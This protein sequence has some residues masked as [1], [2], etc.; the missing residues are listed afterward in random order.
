MLLEPLFPAGFTM[1]IDGRRPTFEFLQ[2]HL[3]RRYRFIER[4][5]FH[6]FVIQLQRGPTEAA[7][8]HE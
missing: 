6:N 3:T 5:R 7:T 1:V 4:P 8:R 2:R